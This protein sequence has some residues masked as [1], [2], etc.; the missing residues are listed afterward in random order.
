MAEIKIK[1]STNNLGYH[2]NVEITDQNGLS[3]HRVT[4]GRDFI[5]RIGANYEPEL[6][7][8]K[9]FEFLLSKEPKEK[10]MEEF[11]LTIITQFFPDYI[12]TLEK[13]LQSDPAPNS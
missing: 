11:D 9:S 1:S 13:M 10:I 3:L 5:L 2:F 7:V 6:V 12:T 8:R 4:M